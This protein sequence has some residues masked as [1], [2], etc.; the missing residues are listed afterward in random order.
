MNRIRAF[1]VGMLFA[2]TASAQPSNEVEMA[3]AMHA[4]GKIYVVVAVLSIVF[5]G[6][7]VYLIGIDRKISKL[8][9][10]IEKK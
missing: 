1:F 6:I 4:S 2:I 10:E 3:D 9:K 8:E 5:L 7:V